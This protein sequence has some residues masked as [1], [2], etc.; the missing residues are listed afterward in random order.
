MINSDAT[1]KLKIE[2][3]NLVNQLKQER[4]EL[5]VQSHL[6]KAELKNEWEEVESKWR[7]LEQRFEH[8]LDESR[9]SAED[10]GDAVKQVGNEIAKA[11]RRMRNQ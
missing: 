7:Y 2:T 10:I 4:D 9:D 6:F 5:R 8:I 1:E 3:T 11:Y